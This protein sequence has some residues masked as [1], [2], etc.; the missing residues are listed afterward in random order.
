PEEV[1]IYGEEWLERHGQS[2][3]EAKAG[4][5]N[6]QT[7]RKGPGERI[8]DWSVL[9][10]SIYGTD[11]S[12]QLMRIAMMNLVL[13]GIRHA[14][15]KRANSLSELGGLTEDDLNRRYKVILSNPPFAG[16]LPKESIRQDLPTDSKKSELLFL[17]LMMKH[18]AAGGRCAVVLPEGVLFGSNKAHVELRRKLVEDFDLRA[19]ISLPAGVFRPYAGVKTAVVVFQ[20]PAEGKKRDADT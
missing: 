1:P 4:I 20:R 7:Y 13:H 12:R 15:L 11:V 18:L 3:A 14:N 16:Q 19:V 17:G 9:E 5:P 8:P 10:A 2:V 6:L